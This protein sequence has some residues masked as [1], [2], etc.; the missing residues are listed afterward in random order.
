MELS[1]T[2]VTIFTGLIGVL[3][4]AAVGSYF[5]LKSARKDMLFK[6][7]LEYFEKL[8]QDMEENFRL[9]KKAI[10]PLSQSAKKQEIENQFAE[11]KK[12]RK[13]FL[14][15]AS[16]L[17]FDIDKITERITDFTNVEKQIFQLFENLIKNYA[18]ISSKKKILY[19]LN[20]QLQKLNKAESLVISEM[21][22]E[23]F[24]K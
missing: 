17:Y 8:S 19:E 14:I 5:N 21:K 7:K 13:S 1:S 24:A 4:G 22:F 6:R 3:C 9:Y 11:L 20:E 15:R 2:I 18:K 12:N 16:P 23:L 10:L